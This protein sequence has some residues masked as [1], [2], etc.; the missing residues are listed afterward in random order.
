M[1]KGKAHDIGPRLFRDVSQG[2]PQAPGGNDQ[3]RP[4]KGDAEGLF[5]AVGIVPHH[6]HI[7]HGV[8][9]FIQEGSEPLGI[10]I[11]NLPQEQFR[12]CSDNFGNHMYASSF[13]SRSTIHAHVWG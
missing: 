3:I 12:S 5:H 8:A 11:G 7:S 1:D 13:V 6:R 2:G 9:V 4:G 10:L